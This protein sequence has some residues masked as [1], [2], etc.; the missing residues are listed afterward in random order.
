[1]K[2]YS[3]QSGLLDR[4][5]TF[6]ISPDYIAFDNNDL[7]SAGL[8]RI[9]KPNIKDIKLL[10]E[11]I[12]WDLFYVGRKYTISVK[13][14]DNKVLTICMK[15]FFGLRKHYH[16]IFQEAV[17]LIWKYYLTDIVDQYL[18]RFYENL[19]TLH[20]GK[21]IL[22]QQGIRIAGGTL[23]LNWLETE[24]KIYTRFFVLSNI[25]KPEDH[26]YVDYNDWHTEILYSLTKTILK[27]RHDS[28]KS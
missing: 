21:F 24:L 28:Q 6:I 8:T 22:D 1:M 18:A 12:Q 11:P 20:V 7:K 15:N 3:I 25:N 27:E 23:Q 17:E 4:Q 26:V 9:N 16:Q 19:E 2:Q 14:N 10:I 5:R 13:D